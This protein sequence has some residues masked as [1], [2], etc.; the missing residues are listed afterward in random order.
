MKPC[1]FCG[2]D[3]VGYSYGKHPDGRDLS[4]IACGVCGAH[5]PVRT[6]TDEWDDDESAAAWNK[7][8]NNHATDDKPKM[9]RFP[10]RR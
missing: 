2:S 3:D 5:G 1:P 6:Y 8:H 4:F 9:F 10:E 7:R